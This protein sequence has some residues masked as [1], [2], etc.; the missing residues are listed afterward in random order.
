MTEIGLDGMNEQER[1]LADSIY[2]AMQR[3]MHDSD[4]SKQ[5]QEFKVGVSDL[6]FCSERLRRTLDRQIP[7]ET[8][9]L[10]AFIGT[11]IG[12]GVEVAVGQAFPE[13][14]VQA[15]VTVT[16]KG[17]TNEYVIPGHLDILLPHGA[18]IDVKTDFGLSLPAKHG[19]DD[20][21]KKFQRHLYAL[22]AHE[23]GLF[24]DG[25]KLD[26]VIVGNAWVDRSGS[27]KRVLV[28]TEPFSMEVVQQ[29]TDWLD[30][31]V[32]SWQQGEETVK[33]PPR[34]MCAVICGFYEPCRGGDVD[35]SG[36]LTDEVVLGAVDLTLEARALESR[37]KKM[38]AEARDKLVGIQGSTGTYQVYWS[39]VG[40]AKI[41]AYERAP[42]ETLKISKIPKAK[43]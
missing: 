15:E 38:K 6:G 19:L 1:E 23:A 14:I 2:A 27:D 39:S 25:V 34:E 5:A 11:W 31:V 37:A 43:K 29:A 21:Q 7:E 8:D 35:A 42:Y 16:L 18:V 28:K 41:E 10:A 26:D 36:L 12:E 13:A 22:G 20:Q 30:E 24:D 4:R 9:M 40:P 3:Q 17:E 33:E 32:Y